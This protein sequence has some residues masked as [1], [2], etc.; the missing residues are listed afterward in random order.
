MANE[1]VASSACCWL[2]ALNKSPT[3]RGMI[4]GVSGVPSIVCVFPVHQNIQ[5]YYMKAVCIRLYSTCIYPSTALKYL[6]QH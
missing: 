2:T 4:P 1:L 6:C 3:H 5:V